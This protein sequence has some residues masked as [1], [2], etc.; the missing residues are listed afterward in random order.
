MKKNTN[1][2]ASY[3]SEVF[4]PGRDQHSYPSTAVK[5]SNMEGTHYHE[6][7]KITTKWPPSWPDRVPKMHFWMEPCYWNWSKQKKL[8]KSIWVIG[9]IIHCGP[10]VI[11]G[12]ACS[13]NW[14]GFPDS[15]SCGK[16]IFFLYVTWMHFPITS[17]C[18]GPR[19][20]WWSAS[21][22]W[23]PG[24]QRSIHL[25]GLRFDIVCNAEFS[26]RTRTPDTGDAP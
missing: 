18:G 26:S 20:T 12:T 23:E 15:R 2:A 16:H 6:L 21:L 11:G 5:L 24:K 14:M 25:S 9:I 4:Q 13:H 3:S 7:L 19:G 1:T 8:C 17:N 10:W 22:F